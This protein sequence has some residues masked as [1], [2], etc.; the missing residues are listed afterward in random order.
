MVQHDNPRNLKDLPRNFADFFE[1]RRQAQSV[2]FASLWHSASSSVFFD[3]LARLFASFAMLVQHAIRSMEVPTDPNE[4]SFALLAGHL[5]ARTQSGKIVS[6]SDAGI[7]LYRIP[8][9]HPTL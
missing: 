9:V 6:T 3:T 4:Q 7:V 2:S 8:F 1:R 5:S